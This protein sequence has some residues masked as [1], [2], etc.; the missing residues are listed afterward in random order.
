M[1]GHRRG[2]CREC[3]G[4]FERQRMT[5]LFCSRTCQR[6][7]NNRR[8]VRGAQLYDLVMAWRFERDKGDPDDVRGL[9]GRLASVYRDADK[10]LRNG[11]KSWLYRKGVDRVALGYGR[12]GDG[13]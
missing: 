2:E 1:S 7:F 12:K 10:A 6:K 5:A 3:G 4:R 11:R 9:I 13:R 8:M